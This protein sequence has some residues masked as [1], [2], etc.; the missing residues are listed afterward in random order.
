MFF[1]ISKTLSFILKPLGILLILGFILILTKNRT[2][3]KR[4]TFSILILLYIFSN[5]IFIGFLSKWY[6]PG[7]IP[8]KKLG[9][10]ETAV[11]LTG[12]ISNDSEYGA[13]FV[14]LGN[15][16]DRIWQALQLYREHKI[17]KI[18]ISGGEW[19][20]GYKDKAMIENDMA[21]LFL[22]KNGVPDSVIVQEKKSRNT[23]ENALETKKKI[24]ITAKILV[25]TTSFHCKR[26]ELCFKKQGFKF[27]M[28]P[29]NAEQSE[30]SS[31]GIN[32]F[33]PSSLAFR[34]TDLL[35]NE[36]IGLLF[37]KL[38]GYI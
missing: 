20:K 11:V 32:S 25:I 31:I 8:I 7:T 29:V 18:V 13:G 6:E 26:A 15:Q 23:Y 28:F 35:F 24:G 1:V 3:Q 21:R 34:Q 5:P 33:L 16:A 12:G 19:R 17:E 36:W 14:G 30:V 2:K 37:Y 27:Q 9:H 22:M 4:L 38:A 10:F